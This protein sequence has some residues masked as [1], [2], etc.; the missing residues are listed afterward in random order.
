MTKIRA[1]IDLSY[2]SRNPD[3]EIKNGNIIDQ[4]SFLSNFLT[5]QTGSKQRNENDS[6]GSL[7]K[8]NNYNRLKHGSIVSN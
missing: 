4:N 5:S 8:N 2:N 6:Y 7:H 1:K 3:E